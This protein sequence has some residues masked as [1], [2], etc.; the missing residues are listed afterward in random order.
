MKSQL[1]DDSS[2]IFFSSSF[3]FFLPLYKDSVI[4]LLHPSSIYFFILVSSSLVRHFLQHVS[5]TPPLGVF[6]ITQRGSCFG[7]F[8]AKHTFF[9]PSHLFNLRNYNHFSF[10]W[11]SFS[12]SRIYKLTSCLQDLLRCFVAVFHHTSVAN[13]FLLVMSYEVVSLYFF[14]RRDASIESPAESGRSGVSPEHMSPPLS[15]LDR[16]GS[17]AHCR[18][19]TSRRK[20]CLWSELTASR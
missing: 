18:S 8:F 1:A 16:G 9:L 3:S 6:G 4:S 5:S 20:G 19:S 13:S 17:F 7:F 15:Q 10:L 11:F 14:L 2:F 12:S